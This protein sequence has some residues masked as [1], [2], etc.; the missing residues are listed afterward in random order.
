V[1]CPEYCEFCMGKYQRLAQSARCS[2]AQS[3]QWEVTSSDLA[4]FNVTECRD[5]AT[6]LPRYCCTPDFVPVCP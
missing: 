4:P 3:V 6:G 1:F 5:L 2:G